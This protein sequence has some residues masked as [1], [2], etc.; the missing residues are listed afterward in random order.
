MTKKRGELIYTVDN[1]NNLKRL[2]TEH[3]G[4][5][6][7]YVEDKGQ[8]ITDTGLVQV[9]ENSVGEWRAAVFAPRQVAARKPTRDFLGNDKPL[10]AKMHELIQSGEVNS[11]SAAALR[12]VDEAIGSGDVVSKQRRLQR[13]YAKVYGAS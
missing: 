8:I 11:P 10:L 7:F 13:A 3:N 6:S 5:F 9:S 12:F 1:P 4:K 2:P